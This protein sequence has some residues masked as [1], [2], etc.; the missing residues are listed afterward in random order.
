VIGDRVSPNVFTLN[1]GVK[2]TFEV[3]KLKSGSLLKR[4]RNK[5]VV[6]I[7]SVKLKTS[8]NLLDSA[9]C[10]NS[11][12]GSL[13][14]SKDWEKDRCQNGDDGDDNKK[15]DEGEP[16]SAESASRHGFDLMPRLLFAEPLGFVSLYVEV[17]RTKP[18]FFHF[19]LYEGGICHFAASDL[20]V[21]AEASSIQN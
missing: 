21:Q 18:W 17:L 15:F 3:R 2:R 11:L 12:G 16:L 6:V 9:K 4:A 5:G 1:V 7:G 20:L 14:L 10:G 19:R 8:S 13:G